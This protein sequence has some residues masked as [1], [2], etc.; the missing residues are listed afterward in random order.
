[1]NNDKK[2][3]TQLDNKAVLSQYL[4]L[5]KKFGTLKESQIRKFYV[6]RTYIQSAVLEI[7]AND[8]FE[9]NGSMAYGALDD[10]IKLRMT[11]DIWR[12]DNRMQIKMYIYDLAVKELVVLSKSNSTNTNTRTDNDILFSL[13]DKGFDTYQNMTIDSISASLLFN[14]AT[15]R[16]SIIAVIVAILSIIISTLG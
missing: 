11:K 13:T 16:L 10:K 1:M 2:D 9:G 12:N 14:K 7:L 3:I 15:N 8:K 4:E 6:R 5:S